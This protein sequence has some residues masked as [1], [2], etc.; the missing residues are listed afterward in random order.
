MEIGLRSKTLCRFA[1]IKPG[2]EKL[3]FL[4]FSYFFLIAAPHTIINALRTTDFL[5]RMT[6]AKLPYAYLSAV[7][8]SGLVVFLYSKVQINTS[9]RALITSS[10]VFFAVSGIFLQW[11]LQTRYGRDSAFI[12][13]YYWTWASVLIVV[14]I[15]G[16]WT[17]INDIY[18]PREAKRLI[19]FLNSGGILGGVLGGLL[20][21]FLSETFLG[22]WLMPLACAMLLGSVFVVRAIFVAKESQPS[23]EGQEPVDECS[24]KGEKPAS[25]TA[26]VRSGKTGSL[27]LSP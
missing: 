2:E 17:I 9:I 5:R 11:V 13:Y 21:G 10:L 4:L 14:L 7:V 15:T 3:A 26:S 25:S 23:K 12:G 18:N 6:P 19:G 8:I 27:F 20:V 22:V 24:A 16:F 1:K